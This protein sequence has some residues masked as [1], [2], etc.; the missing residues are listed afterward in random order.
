MLQSE[1]IKSKLKVLE[2]KLNE[3]QFDI[4]KVGEIYSRYFENKVSFF[5][6]VYAKTNNIEGKRLLFDYETGEYIE[7]FKRQNPSDIYYLGSYYRN[8][9]IYVCR[10]ENSGYLLLIQYELK[11]YRDLTMRD[12]VDIIK[13]FVLNK[14]KFVVELENLDVNVLKNSELKRITNNLPIRSNELNIMIDYYGKYVLEQG[15]RPMIIDNEW[16]MAEF[17]SHKEVLRKNSKNQQLIDSIKT[18]NLELV[19]FKKEYANTTYPRNFR[20]Q[21]T[22][23]ICSKNI[24]V[25]AKGDVQLTEDGWLVIRGF[26]EFN[27]SNEDVTIVEA[28]R[29]Y[30]KDGKFIKTRKCIDNTFIIAQG[31]LPEHCVFNIDIENISDEAFE[32]TNLKYYK[33]IIK[34]TSSRNRMLFLYQLL[35]NPDIEKFYKL[36]FVNMVKE[37][38]TSSYNASELIWDYMGY[39]VSSS[40]N[41]LNK[42]GINSYQAKKIV[43]YLNNT[44]NIGLYDE[45]TKILRYLRNMYDNLSDLDNKTF[46]R[47]FNIATYSEGGNSFCGYSSFSVFR[48]ITEKKGLQTALLRTEQIIEAYKKEKTEECHY[49]IHSVFT[50]Y[51]DV[52][53]MAESLT[54]YFD[55]D[56]FKIKTINDIYETHNNMIYLL[57]K[58]QKEIYKTSF[59]EKQKKWKKYL[60]EDE[61]YLIVAPKESDDLAKE[62]MELHHCVKSYIDAV[63]EGRTNILFLRKKEEPEKPFF[64]IEVTNDDKIRQIHGFANCNI[65]SDKKAHE[66]YLKWLKEKDIENYTSNGALAV[67]R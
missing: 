3:T 65:T 1:L 18:D 62:G 15:N 41:V 55:D 51:D 42:Y 49:N 33:E 38:A 6:K 2:G 16:A 64:T 24:F 13:V 48:K 54:N 67:G 45:R 22:I 37:I 61:E 27:E 44:K 30:Y 32:K 14:Y 26:Y 23:S 39:P 66:F 47:L 17:L 63:S 5:K 9:L 56:V 43:E 58:Y 19:N 46:D 29:F 28:I 59:E 7:D 53:R 11:N 4:D 12:K 40:K 20:I 34:N 36:G 10:D 31:I 52:L 25:Y 35:S 50:T 8:N 21:P 57:N 60:F